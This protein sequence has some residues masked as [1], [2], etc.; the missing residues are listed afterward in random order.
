MKLFLN[1]LLKD[2]HVPN[3]LGYTKSLGNADTQLFVLQKSRTPIQ[4][5]EKRDWWMRTH[6]RGSLKILV[7]NQI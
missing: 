4:S 3:H 5:K 2:D 1:M 6:V 7:F